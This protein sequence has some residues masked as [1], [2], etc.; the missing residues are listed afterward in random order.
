MTPPAGPLP[1][2]ARLLLDIQALYAGCNARDAKDAFLDEEHHSETE[3]STQGQSDF[4]L[5]C[6]QR[7]DRITASR[8]GRVLSCN[9][10]DVNVVS[11]IMGY[12]SS[13]N[14]PS[15]LWGRSIESHASFLCS[16]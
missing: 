5:W 4:A 15:L 8:I 11:E 9:S 2:K 14:V 1:E 6:S 12:V 13:P 3:S 16:R 10:G 7:E